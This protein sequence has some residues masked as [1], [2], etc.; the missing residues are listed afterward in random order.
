VLIGMV[1]LAAFSC[2]LVLLWVGVFR[3]LTPTGTLST[4]CLGADL[5]W[6]IAGITVNLLVAGIAWV[7]MRA[8]GWAVGIAV[9]GV[10]ILGLLGIFPCSLLPQIGLPLL[11]A[12]G[13]GFAVTVV[14]LWISS[15]PS[16]DRSA[17][18]D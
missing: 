3:V 16:F 7:G 9:P 10:G 14:V 2:S 5:A 13:I 12:A 4:M 17:D 1:W 11:A 15:P 6:T 8:S 18:L